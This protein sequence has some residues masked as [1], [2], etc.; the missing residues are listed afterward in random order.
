VV[1]ATQRGIR[2]RFATEDIELTSIAVGGSWSFTTNPSFDEAYT[3][4]AAF[5]EASD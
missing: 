2:L 4:T 3:T 1:G 5:P